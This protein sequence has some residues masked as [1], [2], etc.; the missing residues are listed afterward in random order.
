VTI[1]TSGLLLKHIGAAT[2]HHKLATTDCLSAATE[3]QAGKKSNTL[4]HFSQAAFG[5]SEC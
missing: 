2:Y 4:S 3:G 5:L 1:S